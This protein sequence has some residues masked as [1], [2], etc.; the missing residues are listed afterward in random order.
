M[1]SP[2]EIDQIIKEQIKQKF[3]EKGTSA[4]EEIVQYLKDNGVTQLPT[5]FL[6]V[7]ELKLPFRKA[8]EYVYTSKAWG[9]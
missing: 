7:E 6:L 9:G 5:V 3:S 4:M 1:A 2:F 8:N